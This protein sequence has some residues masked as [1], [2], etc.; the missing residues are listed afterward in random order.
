MPDT[1][2]FRFL[3]LFGSEI[4]RVTEKYISV[5][6]VPRIAPYDGIK[7]FGKSNFLHGM[8]KARLKRA[9]K[10]NRQTGSR[11]LLQDLESFE[12]EIMKE[13][14]DPAPVRTGKASPGFL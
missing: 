14:K 2:A 9:L 7:R 6:L 10:H 12:T 1:G 11:Q 13:P 4:E 8:K 3:V 5:A